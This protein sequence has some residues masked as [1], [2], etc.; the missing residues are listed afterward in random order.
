MQTIR[1]SDVDHRNLT[2]LLDGLPDHMRE[3]LEGL[4]NELSRA[5]V[6]PAREMPADVVTMGSTVVYEDMDTG[7]LL[8]VQIAYPDGADI[9]RG[10][11]SILAPVGAALIGLKV[12]QEISW[13]L[14]NDRIGK[15]RVRQLIQESRPSSTNH[16]LS[17][18]A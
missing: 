9:E 2:G 1:V 5:E 18:P 14:P 13:P 17:L 16:C 3:D 6:L 7:R 11:V 4:E 15:F 10:R 12:G 8:M